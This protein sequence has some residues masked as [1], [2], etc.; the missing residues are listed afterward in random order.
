MDGVN[1][2]QAVMGLGT[3]CL[4]PHV[5]VTGKVPGGHAMEPGQIRKLG[6]D[7][8]LCS[9]FLLLQVIGSLGVRLGLWSASV[10]GLLVLLAFAVAAIALVKSRPMASWRS[11]G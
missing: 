5:L 8:V 1:I 10:R 9:G 4:G 11:H 7:L 6:V 3:L 2:V